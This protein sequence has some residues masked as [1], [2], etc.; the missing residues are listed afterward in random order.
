MASMNTVQNTQSSQL[1]TCH[2]NTI[3][4]WRY[5]TCTNCTDASGTCAQYKAIKFICTGFPN[6]QF[7]YNDPAFSV[8]FHVRPWFLLTCLSANMLH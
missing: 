3:W 2:G 1:A 7:V 8:T 5:K 6:K 4:V